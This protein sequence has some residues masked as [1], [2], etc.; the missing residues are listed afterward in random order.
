MTL[1]LSVSTWVTPSPEVSMPMM[2]VPVRISPPRS[3]ISASKAASRFFAPPLT[4]GA[5]AASS[6]KA[7]TLA[8]W[9]EKASSGPSPACSTQGAQSARTVSDLYAVSSQP[10]AGTSASPRTAASSRGPRRHASPAMSFVVG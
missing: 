10:R 1:P 7:M 8:I 4:I 9:P 2:V 5:P 3:L 6:A